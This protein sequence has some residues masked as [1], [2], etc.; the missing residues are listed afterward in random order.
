MKSATIKVSEIDE[1]FKMAKLEIEI[2]QALQNYKRLKALVKQARQH[3][4]EVRVEFDKQRELCPL[5]E[6]KGE[7]SKTLIQVRA[8]DSKKNSN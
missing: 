4:K 1:Y 5:Y 6:V 3:L 2:N 8:W 7:L